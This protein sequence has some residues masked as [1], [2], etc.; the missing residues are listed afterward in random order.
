MIILIRIVSIYI[1]IGSII[2]FICCIGGFVN[3]MEEYISL[4]QKMNDKKVPKW[5]NMTTAI[6]ALVILWP[7]IIIMAIFN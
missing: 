1:I 3:N 6:L 2:A 5:Y 7:M 4:Y